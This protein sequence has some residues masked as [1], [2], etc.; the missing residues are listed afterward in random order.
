MEV[1][2]D[3]QVLKG[4]GGSISV[5]VAEAGAT[6][7]ATAI[8]TV[9]ASDGTAVVSAQTANGSGG[10][11]TY[12]LTGANASQL[13]TLTASW[14]VT[15]NG[16]G[17]TAVT[18]VEIIGALLFTVAEARAA[19]TKQLANAA[20]FPDALIVAARSRVLN[21]FQDICGVAFVPRYRVDDTAGGQSPILYFGLGCSRV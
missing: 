3:C 8:L 15:V 21:A 6:F 10:T 13:D 9:T 5:T 20:T 4:V 7:G 12:T 17:I 16:S 11:Y 1:S 2:G 19:G 18:S 14:A